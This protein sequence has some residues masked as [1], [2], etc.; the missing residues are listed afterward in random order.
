[1]PIAA[2]ESLDHEAR[3]IARREG[4]T[5]FVDGALPGET[6]E[7]ASF[8]RKPN[9]ELAHLL[10][11]VRASPVRVEARCPHYGVCGGC[12][13]QH[14]DAAAQ[15]AVKQRVLEDNLWHIG[16]VR[17]EQML[18]P[19]QGEPWGYRRRARL[20]VRKVPKKGGVLVGFHER[21][22]SYI[23][24]MRSCEIL[25]PAVS[26]LLLPLRELIAGLSICER[27]PQIEVAMGD[28]C[29][30]LVLRILEPLNA[31]DENLLR[32]FADRHGV[33]LY[34]QPKG[35]DTAVRFHPL[36]GPRLSYTLPEFGLELEFRPT[37]FTQVNHAINRVLVRRAMRLLDPRPG[38]RIADLFCGLGNFTL[39]IASLG[40]SVVGIEGSPALV[41]RGK[42]SAVANGLGARVEFG[43]ANLF[44]CTEESLAALGLF[45]KMLIDPPRE[46]AVEVIKALGETAPRRIVYVSC[47]PATL[48]R[49]AAILVS[50]K[51][52]RFRA[53]GAV[54]MFPH[55]AHVESIA[56]F[57]RE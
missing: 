30:A 22:S 7:Y 34:L 1:M 17:P 44:E 10:R 4:K 53:A 6:V 29:I 25:P 27:L 37:E 18:P 14:L 49:D 36:P 51:G 8:R 12:A 28:S 2:I 45:D 16:R 42:E 40:A 19:I 24:D 26:E 48:A 41:A 21:R 55:T 3:G 46:G 5:I 52:Y 9:Y 32:E 33:V 13:M 56:L 11:V 47:N 38:E 57:D 50:V 35:P 23:A 54:N 15:V 39:P 20:A 43:V 31:T